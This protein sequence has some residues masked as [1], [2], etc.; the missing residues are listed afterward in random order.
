MSTATR[1]DKVRLHY[2]GRLADGTVFDTTEDAG[3]TNFANFKGTGV[4]FGPTALVIGEGEMPPDFEDALVGLAPGQ[5]ATI[6]IRSERAFGARDEARVMVLPID[7]FTPRELGLERFRVAEGRHRPNNFDP[8]VGDVWEVSGPDGAS[9]RARVVA[10]TD[11][12]ITLDA[13]HPL[14]G[15]D[16]FFDVRLVEIL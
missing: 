5:Q 16:L 6:T 1:G 12:T 2:T 14:A 10:R 3:N 8:K 15:H 11:E 9:V 7:D 4:T 13:N